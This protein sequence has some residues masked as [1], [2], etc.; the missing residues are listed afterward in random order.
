MITLY[1]VH[2]VLIYRLY[3]LYGSK[4]VVLGLLVALFAAV[5]GEIYIILTFAPSFEAVDLGPTFGSVCVADNTRKIAL[6]WYDSMT[7]IC[8]FVDIAPGYL[9]CVSSLSHSVWLSIRVPSIS[10]AVL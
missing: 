3:G 1:V 9:F 4:W 6:V 10:R 2:A 5:S 8:R 7:S